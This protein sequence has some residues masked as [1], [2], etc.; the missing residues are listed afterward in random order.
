VVDEIDRWAKDNAKA[1]AAEISPSIGIPAPVLE[2]ALKRQSYG[3]KLL[4]ASVIAEQQRIADT[5][6]AL[7]LVPKRVDVAGVVRRAG[8]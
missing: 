2:I 6:F 5:F 8:S 3:I 4:D 1:V 7:G